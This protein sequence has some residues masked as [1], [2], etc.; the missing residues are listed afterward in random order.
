MTLLHQLAELPTVPENDSYGL[1]T[2]AV[3]RELTGEV[4]GSLEFYEFGKNTV[5]TYGI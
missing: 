5:S 1:A 2:Q 3:V 4:A